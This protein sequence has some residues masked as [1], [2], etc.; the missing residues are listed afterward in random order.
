MSEI[1][2]E[3]A[4]EEEI[5]EYLKEWSEWGCEIS[6]FDW[7]YGSDETAYVIEGEVDVTNEEGK[8][9]TVTAGDLVT[10][11]KGMKCVWDVK[12]PIKKVYTF[13]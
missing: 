11:P 10:F 3:K 12:K 1:K 13:K 4:T 7:E 9:F 2:K 8:V 6:K 5:K